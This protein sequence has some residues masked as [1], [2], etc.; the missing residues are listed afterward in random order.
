MAP[1]T[2]RLEGGDGNDLLTGG[3]MTAARR[4][5]ADSIYGGAGNDTI[6]GGAGDELLYGEAGRRSRRAGMTCS[7]RG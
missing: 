1:A 6:N 2:T 5:Y 4:Y 7:V 3:L